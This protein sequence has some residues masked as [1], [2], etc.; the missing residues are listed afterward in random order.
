MDAVSPAVA[1][2][3]ATVAQAAVV[4]PTNS[5]FD[6]VYPLTVLALLALSIPLALLGINFVLARWTI[7]SKNSNPGK[8]T[9]VESGI[10]N[11]FGSAE[12][13]FSIK[14]YLVAMLF[15]AFDIEVAFL[16]PWAIQFNHGGWEMV[17]ILAVFL[18]ILEVGYIYLY[19]KGAFDWEK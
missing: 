19:R 9:Q 10:A 1:P 7:G 18:V 13:K 3:L 14:F 4:T 8:I 11:S 17:A 5:V 2:A 16:Y 12:E 15:L 6:T